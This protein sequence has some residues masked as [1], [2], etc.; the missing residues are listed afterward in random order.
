M[1]R[2]EIAPEVFLAGVTL[3]KALDV[4]TLTRLAMATTRRTLRRGETLF[5]K[6]DPVTGMFVVVY[7]EIKL[8]ATT[9]ARGRRLSG[10][11]GPGQSFG[12]P[13]MFL[14]RPAP[15]EAQAASDALLLHL[16]KE[17]VFELIERN[18][19]FARRMIAGLS[20]RVERL[21]RELDLQ[22]LGSGKERFIVYLLRHC[23]DRTAPFVVT[24]PV[25]KAEIASQLNLTPEHFSRI[26]HELQQAGLLQMN[27][28]RITLPRPDRLPHSGNSTNRQIP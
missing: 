28:R 27:G 25:P 8:I 7:G 6:G 15:V 24:L 19:K 5:R 1:A 21:V 9:R 18:P 17:A 11:V 22:S 13:T 20:Q 10:M 14:E 2:R 3:F 12:E 16:P 23:R 26:L 4:S